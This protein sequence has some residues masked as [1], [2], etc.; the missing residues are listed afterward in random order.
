MGRPIHRPHSW[1]A[2]LDWYRKV[3]VDLLEG[4]KEGNVFSLLVLL[5]IAILI[6]QETRQFLST[7]LVTDLTLDSNRGKSQDSALDKVKVNFNITM[8]DLKCQVSL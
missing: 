2:G 5:V 7:K 3:P 1:L 4:S 6:F 8:L